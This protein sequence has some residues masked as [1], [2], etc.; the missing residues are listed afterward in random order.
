MQQKSRAEDWCAA[1]QDEIVKIVKEFVNFNPF[2]S[3]DQIKQ[4]VRGM[5]KVTS[6]TR[7]KEQVGHARYTKLVETVSADLNGCSA[8]QIAVLHL[9][10]CRGSLTCYQWVDPGLTECHAV[11]CTGG[12]P[13]ATERQVRPR[14][15][16]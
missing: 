9:I 13:L 16:I 11:T 5:L 8:S 3:M 1:Q 2:P 14:T 15:P 7:A 6:D 10:F 4:A 12:H